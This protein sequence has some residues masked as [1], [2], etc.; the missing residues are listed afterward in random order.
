MHE[1]PLLVIGCLLGRR[2]GAP[3]ARLSS[4]YGSMYPALWSFMLAARARGLGTSLTT[5]HLAREREIAGAL[6]IPYATVTQVA[7]IA[8]G[9]TRGGTFRS[10]TRRPV[11]EVR[12]LNRWP[13]EPS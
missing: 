10:A 7:L 1:V 3:A 8:V 4:F 13:S 11:D 9:H 6:G 2:E 5:A 12:H